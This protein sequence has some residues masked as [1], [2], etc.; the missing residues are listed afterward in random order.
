MDRRKSQRDFSKR[1][2]PSSN[3]RKKKNCEV[4]KLGPCLS[5]SQNIS[6]LNNVENSNC[7]LGRDRRKRRL[8][9]TYAKVLSTAA[10][11]YLLILTDNQIIVIII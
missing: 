3:G 7:F 9:G 6:S 2:K 11:L 10:A 8:T 1:R 4:A 5:S